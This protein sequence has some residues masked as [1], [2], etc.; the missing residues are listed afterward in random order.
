MVLQHAQIVVV[1][2]ITITV[3]SVHHVLWVVLH[4]YLIIFVLV[5]LMDIWD[6]VDCVCHN[7]LIWIIYQY[8]RIVHCVKY[9]RVR[10][11]TVIFIA[12]TVQLVIIILLIS[13]YWLILLAIIWVYVLLI[14]CQDIILTNIMYV[15]YV[16]VLVLFVYHKLNVYLVLVVIITIIA[17]THVIPYAQITHY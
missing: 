11:W 12:L 10:V 9:V 3:I 6:T 14:V 5:A 4:V 17:Q 15:L 7:V 2:A 16:L 1:L 8:C 13:I